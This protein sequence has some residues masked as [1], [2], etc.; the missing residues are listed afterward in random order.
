M[1]KLIFILIFSFCNSSSA[2]QAISVQESADTIAVS[3]TTLT[4]LNQNGEEVIED[5]TNKKTLIV[6]WADY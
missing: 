4:Y 2:T 1:K 6:F 5:L 3:S